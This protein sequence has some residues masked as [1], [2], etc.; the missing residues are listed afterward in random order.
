MSQLSDKSDTGE[1]FANNYFPTACADK[2]QDNVIYFHVPLCYCLYI[3]FTGQSWIGPLGLVLVSAGPISVQPYG[4]Y[5]PQH[6]RF[7]TKL[8]HS[9]SIQYSVQSICMLFFYNLY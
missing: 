5:S 8:W 4:P 7:T 6:I 9:P 3:L 1:H 2:R